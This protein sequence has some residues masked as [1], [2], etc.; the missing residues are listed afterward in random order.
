L[1]A[2]G[3]ALPFMN[4]DEPKTPEPA[5][6][7][8]PEQ[9]SQNST[10]EIGHSASE[11]ELQSSKVEPEDSA[12][13]FLVELEEQLSPVEMEEPESNN[14]AVSKAAQRITQLQRQ[15]QALRQEIANLQASYKVL[16]EQVTQTQMTMGKNSARGFGTAGAT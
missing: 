1:I 12:I 6:E 15:E 4:A 8:L 16:S 10:V 2:L 11:Q 9:E 5:V 7:S 14:W 13:D 3:L